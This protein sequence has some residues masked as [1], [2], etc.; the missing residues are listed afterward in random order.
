MQTSVTDDELDLS[1]LNGM[2]QEAQNRKASLEAQIKACLLYT[3]FIVAYCLFGFIAGLI[4][5]STVLSS[6]IS[7]ISIKQRYGLHSKHIDRG[8][9]V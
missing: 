3:S 5:I 7:L 1:E 6:G 9:F 4:M 8:L 2:I